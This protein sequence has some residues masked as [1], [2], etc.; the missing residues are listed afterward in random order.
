VAPSAVPNI[1]LGS[2]D[3]QRDLCGAQQK[4]YSGFRVWL[5]PNDTLVFMYRV[6]DV[7]MVPNN[8]NAMLDTSERKK[9]T[10]F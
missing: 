1:A 2:S 10:K 9:T 5:A 6:S 3:A 8:I 7:Y 4:S